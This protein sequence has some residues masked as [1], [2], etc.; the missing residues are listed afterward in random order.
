MRG[1]SICNSNQLAQFLFFL[2]IS[3]PTASEVE[4]KL[5]ASA[6]RGL[7]RTSYEVEVEVGHNIAETDGDT[8]CWSFVVVSHPTS[9]VGLK[10]GATHSE[11][12]G[13]IS[14][15][16]GTDHRITRRLELH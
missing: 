5:T 10:H 3:S 16:P 13:L 9:L 12:R 1:S 8:H 6:N 15:I 14:G 4:K 7:D 11:G 2:S